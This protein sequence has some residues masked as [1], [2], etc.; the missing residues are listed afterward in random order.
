MFRRNGYFTEAGGEKNSLD[1]IKRLEKKTDI[2][3]M[4]QVA[5]YLSDRGNVN[6]QIRLFKLA[7]T[8]QLSVEEGIKHGQRAAVQDRNLAIRLMSLY[9]ELP[10]TGKITKAVA[11]EA[12]RWIHIAAE[13]EPRYEEL[14]PKLMKILAHHY[15]RVEDPSNLDEC[16][17]NYALIWRTQALISD[18][19]TSVR[20][21]QFKEAEEGKL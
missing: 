17:N 7:L 16:T 1:A 15:C 2:R 13:E 12:V 8:N 6:A 18:T 14:S 19:H 20:S 3:G 5:R 21:R 4:I 10:D 9:V 11:E